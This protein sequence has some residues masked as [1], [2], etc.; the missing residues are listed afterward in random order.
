M[1]MIGLSMVRCVCVGAGVAPGVAYALGEPILAV[2]AARLCFR[3]YHRDGPMGT[4]PVRDWSEPDRD[5]SVCRHRSKTEH[6]PPVE[7]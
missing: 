7:N 6:H 2:V 3:E 1:L 5:A 4:D